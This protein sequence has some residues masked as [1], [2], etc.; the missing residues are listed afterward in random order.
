MK[1]I[2]Q[3]CAVSPDTDQSRVWKNSKTFDY[4][5]VTHKLSIN[6]QSIYRGCIQFIRCVWLEAALRRLIS[7][8]HHS[9]ARLLPRNFNVN[10][11]VVVF[12]LVCKYISPYPSIYFTQECLTVICLFQARA[13]PLDM[14]YSVLHVDQTALLHF[15][16]NVVQ[17]SKQFCSF[18]LQHFPRF[19]WHSSAVK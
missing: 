10:P 15:Y 14:Y 19:M 18:V 2:K 3:F 8:W 1:I 12:K 9:T 5:T 11:S 16:L 13:F 4:S 6:V 17:Q 7:A